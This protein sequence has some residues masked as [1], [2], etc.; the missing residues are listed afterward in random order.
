MKINRPS[1]WLHLT[2]FW[3]ALWERFK[4]RKFLKEYKPDKP[5]QSYPILV[6]P[7]FMASNISTSSLRRLLNRCGYKAIDWGLGR[8]YANL[9]DLDVLEKKV[10][11]ITEKHQQ[12]MTI[13]GWS[14]GGIYARRLAVLHSSKIRRVIT[15]GSPYRDIKAPNYATWLFNFI[16]S[17]RR[18]QDAEP[19]W[20]SDLNKPIP[21]ASI[22]FYSKKDGIVPWEACFDQLDPT[23]HK[24]IEVNCSHLGFGADKEVLQHLMPILEADSTETTASQFS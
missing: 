7:G 20:I 24:N 23:E 17:L 21:V 6:I 11:E 5:I 19:Q 4:A 15:F 3:R 1:L 22:A 18:N 9:S 2:E 13:I 12:Q 16:Q 8:N 14:L 10:E